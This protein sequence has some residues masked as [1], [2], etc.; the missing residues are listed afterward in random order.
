[1]LQNLNGNEK[2]VKSVATISI[3]HS[4][5]WV[6]AIGI[7]LLF[8]MVLHYIKLITM[9]GLF[10]LLHLKIHSIVYIVIHQTILA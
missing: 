2:H 7:S 4:E 8:H 1:M 10:C 6:F 9:T 3:M 5:Q